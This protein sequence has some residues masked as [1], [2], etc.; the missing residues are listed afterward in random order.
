LI[1]VGLGD[2]DQA[3]IWLS[4]AYEERFNPL[5]LLRPDFDPLRFN[6]H[7]RELRRRE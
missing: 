4:K 3:M 2:Q 6:P 1:F 5:I 7:F